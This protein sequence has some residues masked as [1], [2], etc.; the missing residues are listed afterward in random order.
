MKMLMNALHNTMLPVQSF[1]IEMLDGNRMPFLTSFPSL[2]ARPNGGVAPLR[3]VE[4][5]RMTTYSTFTSVHAEVVL[6][7][8]CSHRFQSNF[9]DSLL[10][11]GICIQLINQGIDRCDRLRGQTASGKSIL[12]LALRRFRSTAMPIIE[13][14]VNLVLIER[15]K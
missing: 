7:R 6:R 3:C 11:T 9:F 5:Q 1:S 4:A 13:L 14:T 10:Q 12:F 2:H 15:T 8:K